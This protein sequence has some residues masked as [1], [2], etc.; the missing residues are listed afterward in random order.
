[1][2]RRAQC[3]RFLRLI[4]WPSAPSA[5]RMARRTCC[6]VALSVCQARRRWWMCL[7]LGAN[8]SRAGSAREGQWLAVE[9]IELWDLSAGSG[10]PYSFV[11][12]SCARGRARPTH[13]TKSKCAP[14]LVTAGRVSLCGDSQPVRTARPLSKAI[15]V[16]HSPDGLLGQEDNQV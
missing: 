7:F 4:R 3:C 2:S 12:L 13:L 14:S 5:Q 9:V 6:P 8:R 1:M 10:P 16:S 11:N 15:A